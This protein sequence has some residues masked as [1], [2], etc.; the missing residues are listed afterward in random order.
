[1]TKQELIMHGTVF[2]TSQFENNK[3]D[4]DTS[5]FYYNVVDTHV[6]RLEE[7]KEKKPYSDMVNDLEYGLLD[8]ISY[9]AEDAE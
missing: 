1:M 5:K 2:L 3:P 8:E 7:E 4:I 9:W 6:L